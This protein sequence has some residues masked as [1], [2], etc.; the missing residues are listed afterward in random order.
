MVTKLLMER[1]SAE[2]K[3]ALIGTDRCCSNAEGS[4]VYFSP[5]DVDDLHDELPE[6]I[7]EII[8]KAEEQDCSTV[9]VN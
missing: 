8:K 7:L 2:S 3:D 9:Q 6:E 5:D 4:E 1:V